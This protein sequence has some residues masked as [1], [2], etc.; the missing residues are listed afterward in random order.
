MIVHKALKWVQPPDSPWTV[1]RFAQHF[2]RAVASNLTTD[3]WWGWPCYSNSYN[4]MSR[5]YCLYLDTQKNHSVWDFLALGSLPSVT[6]GTQ[7]SVGRAWV[8]HMQSVQVYTK[9]ENYAQISDCIATLR[10]LSWHAEADTHIICHIH[11]QHSTLIQHTMWSIVEM[12]VYM[13]PLTW[14]ALSINN[15]RCSRFCCSPSLMIL[16]LSRHQRSLCGPFVVVVAIVQ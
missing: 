9:W 2:S 16:P 5:I 11:T 3:S 14:H 8:R 7:D 13:G 6:S 10:E 15:L 12:A 4:G 1:L